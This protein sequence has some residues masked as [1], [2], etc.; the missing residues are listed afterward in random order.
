MIDFV[1]IYNVRM[2]SLDDIIQPNDMIMIIQQMMILFLGRKE[3]KIFIYI[4]KS[5]S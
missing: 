3:D 4:F 2:K 1:Y 5:Y